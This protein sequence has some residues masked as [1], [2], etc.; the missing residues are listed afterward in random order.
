MSDGLAKLKSEGQPVNFDPASPS[1]PYFI[2]NGWGLAMKES[3]PKTGL[4]W[5]VVRDPSCS[6]DIDDPDEQV[7]TLSRNPSRTGWNTDSGY[8]GYGLTYADARML[9]DAANKKG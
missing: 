2:A 5:Y 1:S 6:Y 3:D 4:E 7:W 9:A 8:N